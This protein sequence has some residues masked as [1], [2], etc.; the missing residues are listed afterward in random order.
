M[1][2]RAGGNAGRGRGRG[3]GQAPQ[4]ARGGGQAPLAAQLRQLDRLQEPDEMT[5][6]RRFKDLEPIQV[7]STY[8]SMGLLDRKVLLPASTFARVGEAAEQP[9]FVSV[10]DADNL[11][12]RIRHQQ[13][14]ERALN[15]REERLPEARRRAS[16]GQLDL[17]ER[18][19][20]L[21]SQKE[22]NSFRARGNTEQAA[23][24]APAPQAPAVAQ[25]GNGGRVTPASPPRQGGAAVAK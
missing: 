14:R 18:R 15:R 5:V 3:R 6:F 21:L 7:Q 8:G 24:A 10:L 12:A 2:T 23:K 25:Q 9:R 17:D 20:L 11:M 22:W 19:I 16:W 4:G 1:S 13:E